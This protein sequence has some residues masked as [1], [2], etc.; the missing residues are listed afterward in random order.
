MQ[1]TRGLS[2]SN[3]SGV[4]GG[5]PRRLFEHIHSA[6]GEI[7][8]KEMVAAARAAMRGHTTD[9]S[10][11]SRVSVEEMRN[12]IKAHEVSLRFA[13]EGL[14]T[15]KVG[16]ASVRGAVARAHASVDKG[17]RERLVQ[18]VDILNRGV[19]TAEAS[20]TVIIL[21]DWLLGIDASG[22]L[23]SLEVYEKTCRSLHAFLQGE[24]LRK[25]YRAT[26]DYFP[27]APR[28]GTV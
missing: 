21:R 20:L 1:V 11:V 16:R 9:F 6:Y 18:F 23:I 3:M 5:L 4:D 7:Y 28:R 12:F 8:S 13:V 10:L 17:D 2:Q 26:Q 25:L 27:L 15:K 24:T 14:V 19:G 22:A